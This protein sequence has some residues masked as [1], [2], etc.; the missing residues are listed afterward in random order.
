MMLGR[1]G[2]GKTSLINLLV[3]LFLDQDFYD[4]RIFTIS[5]Q[6]TLT[7]PNGIVAFD[8][9]LSCT[10]DEFKSKQSDNMISGQA[11]SQTKVCNVYDIEYKGVH[12]TVID[13]PGIGDTQGI[14]Q[15]K[16]NMKMVIETIISTNGLDALCV[17]HNATDCRENSVIRYM[18]GEILY[19]MPPTFISNLFLCFSNCGNGAKLDARDCLSAF[20]VPFSRSLQFES[21]SLVNPK[22]SRN[23]GIRMAE[24]TEKRYGK[25][26]SRNKKQSNK[27]MDGID[28]ID[29]ISIEDFIVTSSWRMVFEEYINIYLTVSSTI[30]NTQEK[31]VTSHSRIRV[32]EERKEAYKGYDVKV[33]ESKINTSAVTSK[34]IKS[35]SVSPSKIMQCMK[36]LKVC[37]NG[38]H[39]EE[40]KHADGFEKI[41]CIAFNGKPTCNVCSHSISEHTLGHT[42]M[43]EEIVKDQIRSSEEVETIE[44][45]EDLKKRYNQCAEDIIHENESINQY[46]SNLTNLEKQEQQVKVQLSYMYNIIVGKVYLYNNIHMKDYIKNERHNILNEADDNDENNNVYNREAREQKLEVLDR[47]ERIVDTMESVKQWPN[48]DIGDDD[49]GVIDRKYNQAYQLYKAQMNGPS[50]PVYRHK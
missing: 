21:S 19:V 17:V 7:S 9:I 27:L 50:R 23:H 28:Q 35:V 33:K 1:S 46:N 32:L 39:D 3:N 25:S 20:N 15:D 37:H 4:E 13:T 43:V 12:L 6:K 11:A 10:I 49:K 29:S 14:D 38:C 5:Q 24:D 34:T 8:V 18:V 30:H 45:D 40:K 48:S 41:K 36:C 2:S 16:K 22:L 47:R 26:W 31:I 44:T 42:K